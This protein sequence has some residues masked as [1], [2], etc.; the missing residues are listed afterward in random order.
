MSHKT[1][2]A[3]Y[4]TYPQFL[5]RICELTARSILIEKE[6]F[7]FVLPLHKQKMK[8]EEGKIGI[9]SLP[10]ELVRLIGGY[11]CPQDKVRLARTCKTFR[12]IL[13]WF[14]L[15]RGDDFEIS[16]PHGGNYCPEPYFSAPKLPAR[17]SHLEVSIRW[18]DQGWGNRKGMIEMELVRGLLYWEPC[19]N[20]HCFLLSTTS[21]F[22]VHFL[23]SERMKTKFRKRKLGAIFSSGGKFFSSPGSLQ[24]SL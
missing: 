3:S 22:Q 23:P 21:R 9:L 8:M 18:K 17:V 13:P 16:G 19:C 24:A 4:C 15:V 20:E 5:S 2:S 10:N 14:L 6:R 1:Q 11:L 7:L 12:Q